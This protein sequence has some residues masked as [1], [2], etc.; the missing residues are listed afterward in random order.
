[1]QNR[2]CMYNVKVFVHYVTAKFS[3]SELF[4]YAV[5]IVG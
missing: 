1:M 4:T 5:A 3:P 2:L